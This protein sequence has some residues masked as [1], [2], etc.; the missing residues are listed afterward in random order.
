MLL[1]SGVILAAIAAVAGLRLETDDGQKLGVS[2][3]A[4]WGSSI[5]LKSND[6]FSAFGRCLT[7]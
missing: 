7:E 4:D 2:S 3:P 5:G 1:F 6:G